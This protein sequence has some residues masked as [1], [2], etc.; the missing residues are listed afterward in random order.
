[1][2]VAYFSHT[3]NTKEAAEYIS[4]Q[5]GADLF[6]IETAQPYEGGNLADRAER[7]MQTNARP[8]LSGTVEDMAQYDVVFVGYPIWYDTAPMAVGTF[9]ESYDW[10]GKTIVPFC[11]SAG[12]PIDGSL[13]LI[14][15]SAE[16]ADILEG[17]T[18]NGSE[19]ETRIW[20]DRVLGEL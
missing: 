18:A 11:T 17:F 20:L 8:A 16:G 2:L 13:G 19:R 14:R 15:G 4:A 7:E 5:T 1:M 6:R 9:L 10:E 3:G 12:S